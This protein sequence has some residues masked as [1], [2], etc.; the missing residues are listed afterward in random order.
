MVLSP[1]EQALLSVYKDS[2][3]NSIDPRSL[4][5]GLYLTE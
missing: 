3:S 1:D 2:D 5:A 4:Q